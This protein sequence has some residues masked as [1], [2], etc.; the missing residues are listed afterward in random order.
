MN[1]IALARTLLR[2]DLAFVL[3]AQKLPMSLY[4]RSTD[5]SEEDWIQHRSITIAQDGVYRGAGW[6]PDGRE[7]S[8]TVPL[9]KK[10]GVYRDV[11]WLP[12]GSTYSLTVPIDKNEA[13][14]KLP[15]GGTFIV[16]LDKNV[17]VIKLPDNKYEAVELSELF[18]RFQTNDIR[19]T[20][21]LKE[22]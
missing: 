21:C 9:E 7:Y 16:P 2:L 22:M 19:N 15:D 8:F 17:A 10:D 13:V 3:K 5:M 18:Y 4:W 6:L 12:E 1:K 11:G 20:K 14:I